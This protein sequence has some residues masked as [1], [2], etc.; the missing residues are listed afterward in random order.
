MRLVWAN[1]CS[2][3]AADNEVHAMALELRAVAEAKVREPD[4]ADA[5]AALTTRLLLVLSRS[6]TYSRLTTP[7]PLVSSLSRLTLL[8]CLLCDGE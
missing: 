7:P 4:D 3:N 1:A 2:Y 5:L 8:T 6:S